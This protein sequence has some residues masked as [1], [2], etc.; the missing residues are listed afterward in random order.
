L[1]DDTTDVV[2]SVANMLLAV[3]KITYRQFCQYQI[4]SKLISI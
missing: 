4:H 3:S 2:N 1:K